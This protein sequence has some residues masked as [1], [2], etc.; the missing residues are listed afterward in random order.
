M[1]LLCTTSFIH[2]S[3]GDVSLFNWAFLFWRRCMPDSIPGAFS[4]FGQVWKR[5]LR[6]VSK[7]KISIELGSLSNLLINITYCFCRAVLLN[8]YYVHYRISVSLRTTYWLWLVITDV[9]LGAWRPPE[10][11]GLR[12]QLPRNLRFLTEPG[13]FSSLS[14][15]FSINLN[16]SKTNAKVQ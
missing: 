13:F 1:C 15:N 5:C 3:G 11:G 10:V 4:D 12:P 7:K 8:N 2:F 16:K 9:L 6:V 14:T